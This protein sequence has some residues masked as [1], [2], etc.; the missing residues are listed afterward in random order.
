MKKILLLFLLIASP[1]FAQRNTKPLTGVRVIDGDVLHTIQSGWVIAEREFATDT[2]A[3][4]LTTA[5]RRKSTVEALIATAANNDDQISL[6]NIPAKWN[7]M[8]F[9]GVGNVDDGTT[10]HL[11]YL[12][13]IGDGLDCSLTYAGQLA[14]TIGP[15]ESMFWL[16]IFT[17]G[18]TYIPVPGDVVVGDTSGA[19]ATLHSFGAVGGTWAGSTATGSGSFIKKSG[20]FQSETAFI[21]HNGA[22]V[23]TASLTIV[24]DMAEYLFADTLVVTAGAWGSP[25]TTTSPADDDLT[26]EAELDVKGAD[27]MV[28]VTT[29]ASALNNSALLVTGY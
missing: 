15:Q 24:G 7:A 13:T 1:C 19:T 2:Q 5:E 21:R 6:F 28:V 11:I 27:F 29:V 22:K 12:G 4:A 9:R 25:W 26:A 10:T 16:Q 23:G 14:W 17:S 3:D 8:R 18:G 20:T